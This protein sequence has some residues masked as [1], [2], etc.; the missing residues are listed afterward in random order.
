MITPDY[1]REPW[2]HPAVWKTHL[3]S[4][5]RDGAA[6]ITVSVGSCEC[7]WAVCARSAPGS[8]GERAVDA[9]VHGHW[10]DVIAQADVV[11]A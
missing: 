7:G 10:C 2:K 3:V 4:R 11:A 8:A 1:H 5:T 6:G 9:A